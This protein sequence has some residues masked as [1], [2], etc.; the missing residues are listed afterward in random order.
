M[1][2]T[3]FA[4]HSSIQQNIYFFHDSASKAIL[5]RVEIQK[6]ARVRATFVR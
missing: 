1:D 4:Q 5:A 2:I 3:P 6:R